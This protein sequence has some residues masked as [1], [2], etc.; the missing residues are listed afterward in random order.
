[1]PPSRP[2]WNLDGG[3][4]EVSKLFI[5]P[6][7]P[8]PAPIPYSS[9][10][11]AALLLAVESFQL[12]CSVPDAPAMPCLGA[13]LRMACTCLSQQHTG[14]WDVFLKAYQVLFSAGTP[15]C[16]IQAR[17]RKQKWTKYV[18]KPLSLSV[19][20]TPNFSC[21]LCF[22]FSTEQDSPRNKCM[23]AWKASFLLPRWRSFQEISGEKKKQ[24]V[25]RFR[26]LLL[27]VPKHG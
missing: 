27:I 22:C 5:P 7:P 9:L 2:V 18:F 4:R 10:L 3:I 8:P 25:C 17:H 26:E 15:V 1:M 13:C 23:K 24:L 6:P 21:F 19:S 20:Q 11:S 16:L 12:D 14:L